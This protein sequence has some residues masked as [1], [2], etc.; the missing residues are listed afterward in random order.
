MLS[1]IA[2]AQHYENQAPAA[3]LRFMNHHGVSRPNTCAV[4]LAYALRSAR[5]RFFIGVEA[6]SG[7][8]WRDLPTRAADLAI[9]LNRRLG[10]PTLIRGEADIQGRRGIVFFDTI[11]GFS[12][13]GHI[14][15]WNGAR[16]ADGG[17]YFRSSPRVYFW[18]LR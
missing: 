16:V 17:S 10:R 18:P 2:V 4:R 14:S 15:L 8:E 12:G 13:T 7:V 6:R 5:S 11:V 9:I 1:Y 3:F